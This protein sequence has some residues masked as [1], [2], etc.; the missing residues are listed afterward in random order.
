[1][2]YLRSLSQFGEQIGG[3]SARTVRRIIERD[4]IPTYRIGASQLVR[5]SDINAWIEDHRVDREGSALKTLVQKAVE[6]ARQRRR[7]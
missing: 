4:G 1:M 7:G 5:Q 6:R 2:D 3:R